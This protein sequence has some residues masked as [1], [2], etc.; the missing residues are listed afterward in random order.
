MR[1]GRRPSA[2]TVANPSSLGARTPRVSR[3][4]LVARD[5]TRVS[6][7]P[8]GLRAL[9]VGARRRRFCRRRKN[10]LKKSTRRRLFA[11]T[12][13]SFSTRRRFDSR[14]TNPS[15]ARP[16]SSRA[17]PTRS[18]APRPLHFVPR[19]P[20]SI[21]GSEGFPRC[22]GEGDATEP[23]RRRRARREGHADEEKVPRLERLVH[24]EFECRDL[25]PPA[26]APGPRQRVR[27]ARVSARALEERR[28]RGGGEGAVRGGGAQRVERG[29]PARAHDDALRGG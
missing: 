10:A 28:G 12:S 8:R 1:H 5:T 3:R 7:I 2:A 29:A 25:A 24:A 6:L 13:A 15:K 11:H 26:R 21:P 20:G 22:H 9:V 23:R 19:P 18:H 4:G 14:Q 17:E 16:V 27:Q